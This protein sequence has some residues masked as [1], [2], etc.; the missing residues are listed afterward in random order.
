VDKLAREQPNVWRVSPDVGKVLLIPTRVST[1]WVSLSETES[2][3][4]HL[5]LAGAE[6][7]AAG[8]IVADMLV[9]RV[10]VAI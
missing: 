2:T 10:R 8:W 1:K 7:M 4:R 9:V 5:G 6:S 3:E